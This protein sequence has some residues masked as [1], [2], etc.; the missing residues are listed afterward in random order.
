M[1]IF[2]DVYFAISL[3][4]IFGVVMATTLDLFEPN[5]YHF[6]SILL[7]VVFSFSLM[8][9]N[10]DTKRQLSQSK[11][12]LEKSKNVTTLLLENNENAARKEM[13]GF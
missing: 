4:S 12:L 2:V 3:L 9:Y 8:A 7:S 10:D 13:R 1:G 6:I 5:K 11:Y